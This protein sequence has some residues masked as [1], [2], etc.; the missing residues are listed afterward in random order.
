MMELGAGEVL[1]VIPARNEA[2]TVAEVVRGV[3]DHGFPVALID[4]AS[5]D[6]TAE[7]AEGAGAVVLRL[8]LHLGV[9]GALRCGFRY[10]VERG[11]RVAVQCDADG[12]HDPDEV[13][14][15]LEVMK[16]ERAHLVVGS[17]F[18][19][20]AHRSLFRIR[21]IA[22]RVLAR[23]ASRAAGTRI[24]DSTSGF[25]AIASP[26]LEEFARSYPSQY[27]GDTF[28]VLVASARAG[29]K[30]VPA[31]TRMHDRQGGL[32]STG[33]LSSLVFLMRAFLVVML[34]I[35]TRYRPPSKE[36]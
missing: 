17:R 29:Y 27:L 19:A 11:Y 7:L 26:L 28:E 36:E 16:A 2:A 4:D 22:M 34:R 9:G 10:A 21:H 13:T 1:V 14:E 30:V 24:T 3:R 23:A 18:D 15:L 32:P 20:G 8:P 25:R 33:T 5:T 6:D 35:G 31:A 12:Q